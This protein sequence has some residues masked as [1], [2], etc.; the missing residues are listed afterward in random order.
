MNKLQIENL[1]LLN[2]NVELSLKLE[3]AKKLIEEYKKI[4]N[5]NVN[6]NSSI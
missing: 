5:K 3:K 4:I 6:E 1:K 2:E